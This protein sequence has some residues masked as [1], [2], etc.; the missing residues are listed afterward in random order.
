MDTTRKHIKYYVNE[1]LEMF[2]MMLLIFHS[3]H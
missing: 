1:T 2:G 3:L